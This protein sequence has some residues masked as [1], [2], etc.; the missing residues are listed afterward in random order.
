[1]EEIV[2]LRTD[3]V[4]R[5]CFLVILLILTGEAVATDKVGRIVAGREVAVVLVS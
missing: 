2:T 3:I 4:K 1:M 5:A